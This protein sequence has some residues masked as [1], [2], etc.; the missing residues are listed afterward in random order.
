MAIICVRGPI[1]QR[2]G[3][4]GEH[5]LEASNVLELLRALEGA[6]PAVSGWILDER[7]QIRR[8][9]NI[10]VNGERGGADTELGG[11]DRVDVVP[12]ITGG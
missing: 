8:H 5:S 11:R 9:I 10:Y 3:G 12:S 6:H 4:V 1:R 7:G 2:T